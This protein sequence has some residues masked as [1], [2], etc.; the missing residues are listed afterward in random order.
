MHE[1]FSARAL[2][3][4]NKYHAPRIAVIIPY[5]DN[6]ADLVF[7]ALLSVRQQTYGHFTC[8]LVDDFSRQENFDA[9]QRAIADI[10]DD[11]FRLIRAEANLGQIPAVFLG[12]DAVQ[13]DFVAVL[14]PDDRYAPTF[15]E[16]M[17][18]VH[19]NSRL[20]C[21]LVSCDQYYLNLRGGVITGTSG[22]H[23]AST[24]DIRAAE[25]ENASFNAFG[26]HRF[27]QPEQPGWHWSSTSSMMF[28]SAALKLLRPARALAYK[29]HFDSYCA[30]GAH[31]QGG[32]LV[33]R[34]PLVYRGLHGHNDFLRETIFSMY[35][36]RRKDDRAL[37]QYRYRIDAVEAFLHNGGLEVFDQS[38]VRDLLIAQFRGQEL[39]MLLRALPQVA[40]IFGI[41]ADDAL[42]AGE[43]A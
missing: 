42:V 28:R 13:A 8:I 1:D 24:F 34:E 43:G 36:I 7:D 2:A 27:V 17:L 25:Q 6:Y 18:A 29:G 4:A 33:L 37:P 40:E 35:Q 23:D 21:P 31:M 10:A 38:S 41:S 9:A 20:F 11:R 22:D 39:P 19:L 32:S 14:D 26:F 5:H 16:R 3:L 15:L 12:L 30:Q